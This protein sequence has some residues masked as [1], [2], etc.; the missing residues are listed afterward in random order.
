MYDKGVSDREKLKQVGIQAGKDLY[1][2]WEDC[3]K[4]FVER[5]KEIVEREKNED[6][7]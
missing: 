7:K 4:Q 2:S 1:V 5:L 6:K 3:T